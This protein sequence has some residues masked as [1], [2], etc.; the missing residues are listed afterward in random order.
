MAVTRLERKGKRNKAIA[1]NRIA[2]IKYLNW[3][4]E[5]KQVDVEAIKAEF[6]ANKGKKAAAS[7]TESEA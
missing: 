7:T 1:N 4:P 6:E 3:K 2:H 5:I